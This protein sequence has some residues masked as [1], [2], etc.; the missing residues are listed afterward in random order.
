MSIQ[1]VMATADIAARRRAG[2]MAALVVLVVLLALLSLGIG[3][4]RLS[5]LTVID[6]LFGGGS[7]VAQV[8][9]RRNPAAAGDS[10]ACD[11]RAFS[12]C[13][14]RPC[15]GCCAIRWP[16]PRL[17]GAPQ[18]AAFGA[19][20]VIALGLAD[21]R[22]YALPVAAIAA[23][24]ASVFA[25][26]RDRGPQCRPADSHSGGACDL[27]PCGSRD[28]A[29]DESVQQSL[30]GARDRVL[31]ARLAGGS[32]FPPRHAGAAVHRR[33]RDHSVEPA[34]C[35]PRA[36]PRR[37]NRAK[38]RRRCRPAAADGDHRASRSASAARSRC[39]AP[40]A[41]SA[42]WRRI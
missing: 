17:F 33:G 29:G 24:F 31:A 1:N 10:R 32:Q 38:P 35:L 22:S 2:V 6:A 41:S 23:A 30:R 37:G 13:P 4:V 19:V 39:P 36:Q 27:E 26:A 14:A 25:A 5:P 16:R 42:W 12:G 40:S 8:I 18:S 21:V 3:P 7:D 34:P 11:R 9:V 28:R 15:R 20:L